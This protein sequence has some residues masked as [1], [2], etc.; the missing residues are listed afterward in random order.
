MINYIFAGL[1]LVAWVILAIHLS[2][3]EKTS[4]VLNIIDGILVTVMF[5][6]VYWVPFWLIF[7]K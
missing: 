3:D 5:G 7:L 6:L 1:I 4:P 2:W